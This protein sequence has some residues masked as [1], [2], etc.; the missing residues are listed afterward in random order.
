[1]DMEERILQ[2]SGMIW[3]GNYTSSRNRLLPVLLSQPEY[4]GKDVALF[5]GVD[6]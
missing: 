5:E 1:M 4:K 6:L 3:L 2:N